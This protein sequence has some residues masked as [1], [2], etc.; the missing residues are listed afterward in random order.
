MESAPFTLITRFASG[1]I[2]TSN[3]S[4]DELLTVVE[5]MN[6]LVE[7]APN[8]SFKDTQEEKV[9]VMPASVETVSIGGASQSNPAPKSNILLGT[10]DASVSAK[11]DPVKYR[12]TIH[13]DKGKSHHQRTAA[14]IDGYALDIMKCANKIHLPAGWSHPVRLESN[15]SR[16]ESARLYYVTMR[17][18]PTKMR[19]RPGFIKQTLNMYGYY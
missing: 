16:Y 17:I 1:A 18:G 19:I 15:D 7:A 10:T 2:T 8:M 4:H 14:K 13:S 3:L 5:H 6:G 12:M 11:T 9:T